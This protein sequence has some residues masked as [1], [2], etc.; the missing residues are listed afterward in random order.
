MSLSGDI[1]DS[2]LLPLNSYLIQFLKEAKIQI[3]DYSLNDEDSNN[4]HKDRSQENY[5]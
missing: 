2:Q 4:N 3:C 5:L 1:T